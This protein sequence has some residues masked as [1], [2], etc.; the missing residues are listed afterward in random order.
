LVRALQLGLTLNDLDHITIGLI[1]DMLTEKYEIENN[2]DDE[3]IEATADIIKN[4]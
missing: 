1:L 4:F 2:N 3:I